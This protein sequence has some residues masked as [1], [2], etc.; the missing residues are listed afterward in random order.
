MVSFHSKAQSW[1]GEVVTRAQVPQFS[2]GA[3]KPR[4]MAVYDSR[5]EGPAHRVRIGTKVA[6][7]KA[8]LA[9]WLD[10]RLTKVPDKLVDPFS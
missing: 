3:Y 8:V 9:D 7:P 5:G 6:Y 1:P 10:S 4:S 2:D